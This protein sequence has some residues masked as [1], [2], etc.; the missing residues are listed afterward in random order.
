[1]GDELVVDARYKSCPGP[2]VSLIRA[3]RRA[4][5]GQRIKLLST[6]PRS[7]NDVR[8]WASRTGHKFLGYKQ[9]DEYFEIY[10]EV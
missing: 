8:E 6:D 4:E 10:V 2:L 7:P 9:I 5:P 1:M 3:M